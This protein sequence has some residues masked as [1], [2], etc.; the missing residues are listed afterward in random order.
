MDKATKDLMAK[1]SA[2]LSIM[3]ALGREPQL[4]TSGNQEFVRYVANLMNFRAGTTAHAEALSNLR[5]L[6]DD[7]AAALQK[8]GWAVEYGGPAVGWA[9]KARI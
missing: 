6:A 5:T 2:Q 1:T 9:S 4:V 3:W 7:M 8:H